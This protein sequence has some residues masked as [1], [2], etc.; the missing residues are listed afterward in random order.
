MNIIWWKSKRSC[1]YVPRILITT[2]RNGFF[3]RH[4]RL[5]HHSTIHVSFKWFPFSPTWLS[6][7]LPL[8]WKAWP[9]NMIRLPICPPF[10]H[11]PRALRRSSI[12]CKP[13]YRLKANTYCIT[14]INVQWTGNS[15]FRNRYKT[16]S[17]ICKR[18]TDPSRRIHLSVRS[19]LKRSFDVMLCIDVMNVK[20][21]HACSEFIKTI[22]RYFGRNFWKL[23]V[24]RQ[25]M[26]FSSKQTIRCL[27]QT[28]LPDESITFIVRWTSTE[29]W[30]PKQKT[31]E[32]RHQVFLNCCR[33]STRAVC[34]GRRLFMDNR[35]RA[36]RTDTISLRRL[37]SRGEPKA[38]HPYPTKHLY[39]T[40]VDI[41][42]D[43]SAMPSSLS[44]TCSW[45]F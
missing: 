24:R 30:S 5:L 6:S 25:S 13:F 9:W 22:S 23:K 26:V 16:I 41:R 2:R 44:S 7:Y 12:A 32:F 27:D 38:I 36:S 45:E 21:I 43:I 34:H 35:T 33:S 1:K 28:Y 8:R 31:I 20:V 11:Y 39:G 42:I 17:M 14:T 29:R 4:F 19:S 3:F 18:I 15:R 10:V 40:R 37:A